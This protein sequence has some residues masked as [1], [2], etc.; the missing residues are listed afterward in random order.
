MAKNS[1]T[2]KKAP[3]RGTRGATTKPQ[4]AAAEKGRGRK[5]ASPAEIP[6]KGWKDIGWRLYAAFT[7]DHAMLVAAG[8]TYYLLLALFPA[9]AAFVSLY[10]FVADPATV[11]DHVAFLGG[12]LP[13]GGYDL[14]AEQLEALAGQETAALSF[15][16][17]LGLAIALWSANAGIK[18]MFE[19]MNIAY[20]EKEKRSFVRLNLVS[21]AFTFGAII[22]AI[23]LI[24]T[25]GV[26]PAMLAIVGLDGWSETLVRWLRWPVMLLFVAFAISLVYRY[27]PS[28]ERA[29]WR[30][31]TW[32]A[33]VATVVWVAAS[34]GFS[35]YLENFADYNAT[36]GTLG[37]IIGFMVWTWIS[38]MI[39][40]VGAE[41]NA[42][43]E[44]QTAKDTTT[45]ASR[46]MGE[47]GAVVADTIGAAQD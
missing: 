9:L 3:R 42:A 5:A 41:L 47:R 29:K 18:S 23:L 28:R 24:V 46:P 19:A 26:V 37:A 13:A 14:I 44:H 22:I 30:W 25:V 11:A 35:W 4:S 33:V 36:Y 43:L 21:L 34:V 8:A 17:L 31:L 20:R 39:V 6:A 45:G 15:G 40:V 10:G 12:I 32:G 2:R 27:G 38:V 1:T 7:E 16:F